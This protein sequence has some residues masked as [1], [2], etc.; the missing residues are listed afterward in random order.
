MLDGKILRT[1]AALLIR[2]PATRRSRIQL[3][4]VFVPD[5]VALN[6]EVVVQVH[7][8]KSVNSPAIC[9]RVRGEI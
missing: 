5:E 6:T 1:A 7:S 8:S 2:R 3:Q 9:R 4:I